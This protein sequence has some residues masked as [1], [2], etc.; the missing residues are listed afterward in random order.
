[1]GS[2]G[3]CRHGRRPRR[4]GDQRVAEAIGRFEHKR[5]DRPQQP[6]CRTYERRQQRQQRR[7]PDFSSVW[8]PGFDSGA[9]KGFEFD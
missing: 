2:L 8:A 3:N 6:R 9:T 1:M 4:G 5:K 7:L